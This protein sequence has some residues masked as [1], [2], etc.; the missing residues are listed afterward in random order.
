MKLDR[1]I[2]SMS[3]GERGR[4]LMR[5]RTLIRTHKAKRDNARCWLNDVVLYNKSL[6]EG[7]LGAGAMSQ[8]FTKLIERCRSYIRGQQRRSSNGG[9][10][11]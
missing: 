4:E 8:P 2:A 11:G 3:H 9:S 6:P 1:D 5:L 10:C 7:G